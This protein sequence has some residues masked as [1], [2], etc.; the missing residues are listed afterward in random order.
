MNKLVANHAALF[1]TSDAAYGCT[2]P[3]CYGGLRKLSTHRH[4]YT[5]IHTR[6][7]FLPRP[8]FLISFFPLM[9][10]CSVTPETKTKQKRP[11]LYVE[12]PS[13]QVNSVVALP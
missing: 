13:V 11:S 7:H 8:P 12:I 10:N 1:L 2:L 3:A 5:H 9:V 6:T 4:T